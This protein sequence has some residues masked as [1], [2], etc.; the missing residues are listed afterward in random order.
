MNFLE[1]TRSIFLGKNKRIAQGAFWSAVGTFFGSAISILTYMAIARLLGKDGYGQFSIVQTTVTMIGVTVGLSFG[2]IATKDVAILKFDKQKLSFQL[3]KIT[4]SVLIV[5]GIAFFTFLMFSNIISNE[6]LKSSDLNIYLII[7]SPLIILLAC[8]SLLKS[9]LIGFEAM[10]DFAFLTISGATLTMLFC[11]IGAHFFQIIGVLLGLLIALSFQ[12]YLGSLF[13]RKQNLSSTSMIRD[14]RNVVFENQS[15]IYVI[16]PTLL[17]AY[18]VPLSHWVSQLIIARSSYGFAAVAVISVSLQWYNAVTF[19]PTVAGRVILP[20]LAE[21]QST[22]KHSDSY[23]LILN[24][25]KINF[26][27]SLLVCIGV[28]LGSKFIMSGYGSDFVY[29]SRA[30]WLTSGAAVL[31]ISVAPI[32]QWLFATSKYWTGMFLNAIW[33]LIFLSLSYVLHDSMGPL[34]IL[35]A[36]ASAYAIHATILIMFFYTKVKNEISLNR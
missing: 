8:D 11:I 5:T 3:K 9:I 7:A 26:G 29:A 4:K 17:S 25:V 20:I 36:L 18:I 13:I 15:L 21:F 33:A 30:L 6:I 34:G 31:S 19:L 23:S 24:N 12:C 14:E 35:T 2:A 16:T 28:I 32:G 22:G 10:K 1:K 27:V